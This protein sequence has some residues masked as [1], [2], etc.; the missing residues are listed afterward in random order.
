MSRQLPDW[1]LLVA[2]PALARALG[3]LSPRQQLIL[4]LYFWEDRSQA[5]IAA[6]LG[7]SQQAVSRTIGRALQQLGRAL[8]AADRS[9]P[10]IMGGETRG[11][12]R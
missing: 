8:G 7:I 6:R 4:H 12:G 9:P 3:A 1:S 2:H 11:G 10:C 5:D